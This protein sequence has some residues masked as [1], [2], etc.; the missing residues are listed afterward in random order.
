MYKIS[1][2]IS[3]PIISIYESEYFGIVYN[4]LIDCKY[5]KIKYLCILNEKDNIPKILNVKDIYKIGNDCIFIKNKECITLQS[6]YEQE[7][8]KYSNPLN[9]LSYDF[10]GKYLGIINDGIF[11]EK[12]KLIELFINNNSFLIN[13]IFNIGQSAIIVNKKKIDLK[14]FK[15]KSKIIITEPTP[16]KVITLTSELNPIEKVKEDI[17][18][19]KIITDFRFL[20]GRILSKDILAI[21]G[22]VIAKNGT[23]ITKE[24]I[25][26]ASFYGKLVEIARYSNK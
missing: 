13:N 4:I 12:Y 20:I 16:Q 2:I 1:D 18:S 8:N 6:N 26:K 15:P 11:D 17:Q 21:N 24:I 22:E 19:T 3:M 9:L 23:K 10:E 7:I 5:K 14:K 25:N